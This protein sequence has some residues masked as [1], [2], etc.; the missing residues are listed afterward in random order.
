MLE[1]NKKML[2]RRPGKILTV[3]FWS[4]ILVFIFIFITVEL[5]FSPLGP[6]KLQQFAGSLIF[7]FIIIILILCVSV[8]FIIAAS[9]EHLEKLFKSFLILTGASAIGF[10]VAILLH[11]LIYSV[12]KGSFWY[13]LISGHGITLDIIFGILLSLLFP[14]VFVT[15]VIG[16]ITLFI[17]RRKLLGS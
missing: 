4:L 7:P 11:T 8:F 13:Y 10:S 5:I 1:Q 17:K 2:K 9:R 14:I 3:L 6:L 12:F 16:S 15:G